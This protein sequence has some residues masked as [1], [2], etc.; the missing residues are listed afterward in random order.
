M[1]DP[2]MVAA[3]MENSAP[4]RKN[5]RAGKLLTD[6]IR[7]LIALVEE[8][9]ITEISI[10]NGQWK[11]LIKRGG[12]AQGAAVPYFVGNGFASAA[13]A[14]APSPAPATP[15]P[16][17]PTAHAPAKDDGKLHTVTAPMVGTFFRSPDPKARPFVAEGEAVEKGQVIGIIE[18]MKI[19][20]E[21]T[22]DFAGK[23]ARILVENGQPV[24]YGQPLLIIEP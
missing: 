19:M 4:I 2:E 14:A 13:P 3:G 7:E 24:E 22:S 15:A 11:V 1:I 10:D 6:D 18:A 23:C 8:S 16:V 12:E 21:I 20:N 9:Q 5:G 17:A